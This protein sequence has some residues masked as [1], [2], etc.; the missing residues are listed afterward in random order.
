MN[1]KKAIRIFFKSVAICLTV[2]IVG[3]V[4]LMT[5]KWNDTYQAYA[6]DNKYITDFG[7][8][9]VSAHRSGAGIFPENTMMAFENCINSKD[10]KTDMFE[11]DLHITKDGELILLH[12]NTLDRTTDAAEHFGAE[13]IR[14]ENYTYEE[15]RELNFGESFKNEKGETPYKGLRDEDI[16]EN[17]RAARLDDVLTYLESKGS[18]D[19]IIEIKNGGELG[20]KAADKLYSTL[21]EKEL[22]DNA[23]VGTFNGDVTKY[24]DTAYPDMSR[25]ASIFEVVKFYFLSLL[26]AEAEESFYKFDALQIPTGAAIIDLATVRLVN[27]AHRHNIS[28]QYWT[29]NDEETMQKLKEIG[30]DCI[31]SDVPDLAYEVLY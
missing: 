22:L 17:L 28:V 29:I 7:R 5:H 10:F 13:D 30:A 16:P 26:N 27:Y 9:M 24:M 21:K 31:M 12:D 3:T 4:L 23:V 8:T 1:K 19:Y 18:F 6:C 15:L 25:S 11:F 14:P 20:C 2:L